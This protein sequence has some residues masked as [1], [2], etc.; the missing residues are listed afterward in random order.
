M[1]AAHR[2]AMITVPA[3]LLAQATG[4]EY[5]YAIPRWSHERERAR[6]EEQARNHVETGMFVGGAVMVGRSLAGMGPRWSLLDLVLGGAIADL[7]QR[8]Y[9]KAHGI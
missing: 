9:Y 5:R 3:I 7:A 6:D 2:S 8:E 1:A 4:L